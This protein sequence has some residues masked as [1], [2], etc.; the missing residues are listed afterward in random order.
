[1]NYLTT[2]TPTQRLGAR[3]WMTLRARYLR[4]HPLCVVCLTLGRAT[5]ATDLDHIVPLFR[6]GTHEEENLQGLCYTHHRDKTSEDMN[7]KKRIA[8]GLDGWPSDAR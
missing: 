3:A 1:M 4:L 5:A 2:P 8:I 6:G 7:Y